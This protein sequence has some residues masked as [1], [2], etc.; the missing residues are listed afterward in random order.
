V[1]ISSQ[2][3]PSTPHDD[4]EAAPDR[5]TEKMLRSAVSDYIDRTVDGRGAASA[6]YHATK[7][8]SGRARQ[9][10][11]F[12]AWWREICLHWA[13]SLVRFRIPGRDAAEREVEMFISQ[14]MDA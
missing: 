4:S 14:K 13:S 10:P 7:T 11:Q 2:T 8:Q 6:R 1:P 9:L 5:P 3:S 12:S